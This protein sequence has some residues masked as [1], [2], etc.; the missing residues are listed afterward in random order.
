L[1]DEH[2]KDAVRGCI[3]L[4]QPVAALSILQSGVPPEFEVRYPGYIRERLCE[5]EALKKKQTLSHAEWRVKQQQL[6][7]QAKTQHE[8]RRAEFKKTQSEWIDQKL[9]DKIGMSYCAKHTRQEAVKEL[10]A[11]Q[12]AKLGLFAPQV[13]EVNGA[14]YKL[15]PTKPLSCEQC[16]LVL[17][18]ERNNHSLATHPNLIQLPVPFN[19]DLWVTCDDCI[20]RCDKCTITV[21]FDHYKQFKQICVSCSR[22]IQKQQQQQK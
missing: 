19:R 11:T 10:G 6:L 21:T 1:A 12:A 8:Q 14:R 3:L 20:K 4:E 18:E 13:V 9:I 2:F 5:V 15:Q 22:L 17:S 16:G 7:Q